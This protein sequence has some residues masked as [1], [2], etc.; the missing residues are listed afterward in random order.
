MRRDT[1]ITSS[2]F[3]SSFLSCEKDM[4]EILRKLFIAS[5][6]YSSILKRLL[7]INTK[8][9]LD[10]EDSVVIE[11]KIKEMS[12]AKL[13]QEGY[14]RLEPKLIFKENEEIKAYIIIYCD[15]YYANATNPY[16]RDCTINFNIICHTDYWDL[17]DYRIRPLKIAGYIDG[18]L[19][20]AKLSGIGRLEFVSC[21][22][23]VL[24]E[25]L[26]GYSLTYRA[27]HGNDDNLDVEE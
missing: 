3:S 17:G 10:N 8:D 12:L 22:H 18:V 27:I 25:T 26:S 6:P 5:E 24:N 9:C 13:R 20:K 1:R 14:I 15:N 4:E 21:D 7:V 11:Q 2:E 19:N 23:I 16:F